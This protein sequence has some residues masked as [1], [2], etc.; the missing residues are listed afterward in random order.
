MGIWNFLRIIHISRPLNDP[1]SVFK[2]S[3]HLVSLKQQL[4]DNSRS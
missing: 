3:L 4:K 2:L 1:P